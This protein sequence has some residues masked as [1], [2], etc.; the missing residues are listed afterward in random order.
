MLED[1]IFGGNA[2]YSGALSGELELSS[3]LAS[4]IDAD[5]SR[6]DSLNSTMH[7]IQQS[8]QENSDKTEELYMYTASILDALNGNTS[9]IRD[10]VADGMKIYMDSGAMVG[11][12]APEMD[13]A[14]GRRAALAER[15]VY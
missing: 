15:G 1:S 5:M 13:R 9:A 12:L 3:Q 10:S 2:I 8:L 11:A 7:D 14:L 4:M 6:T